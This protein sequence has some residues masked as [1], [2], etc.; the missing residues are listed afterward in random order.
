M[1]HDVLYNLKQ[2]PTAWFSH[3]VSLHKRMIWKVLKWEILI[4][5]EAIKLTY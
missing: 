2:A 3:K 4:Y 1:L 5:K